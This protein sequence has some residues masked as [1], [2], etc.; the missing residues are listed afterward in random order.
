MSKLEHVEVE[1]PICGLPQKTTR[2]RSLNAQ[3]VPDVVDEILDGSFA[4]LTCDGCGEVWRP[5]QKMLLADLPNRLWAVM[6]PRADRSHRNE[7]EQ[8]VRQYFA[9]EFS[10]APSVVLQTLS[11]CQ[12]QLVF[13][14]ERLA[15]AVRLSRLGIPPSLMEGLKLLVFRDSLADFYVLGEVEM[16]LER[17]TEDTLRFGVH[18]LEDGFRVKSMEV[19][20]SR[21]HEVAAQQDHFAQHYPD[22][23]EKPNCDACRYLYP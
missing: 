5:E 16:V 1:C 2:F 15:E 19:P 6:H 21:L 8:G 23:F 7:L 12:V 14:H 13:G 17:Q 20:F 22:L 9:H 11:E 18:R 4:R 3:R 10:K